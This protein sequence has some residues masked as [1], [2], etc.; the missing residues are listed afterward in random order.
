MIKLSKSELHNQI[1]NRY[2]KY[3]YRDIGKMLAVAIVCLV[4]GTVLASFIC[5]TLLAELVV[6]FFIGL[7]PSYFLMAYIVKVEK[8]AVVYADRV[9]ED[10]GGY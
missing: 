9:I 3:Y 7:L 10:S 8:D 5:R 4:V 1:V 2:R 6:L